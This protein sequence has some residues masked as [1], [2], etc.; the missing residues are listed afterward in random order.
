MNTTPTPA[1]HISDLT[2][3][4][5]RI[6]RALG[7]G[8][9]QDPSAH[10]ERSESLLNAERDL[11]VLE[12]TLGHDVEG[13]VDLIDFLTKLGKVKAHLLQDSIRVLGHGSPHS[14]VTG[15]PEGSDS[16]GSPSGDP[17]ES[18][19]ETLTSLLHARDADLDAAVSVLPKIAEV[20][21]ELRGA[22]GGRR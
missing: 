19:I 15:T 22:G 4:L 12:A 16:A 20:L 9:P 11:N 17:A 1:S 6:E 7:L 3:R 18:C 21:D 8:F 10:L 14:S 13:P 2:D 5:D